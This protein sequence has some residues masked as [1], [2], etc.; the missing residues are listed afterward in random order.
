MLIY[1][2]FFKR[3]FCRKTEIFWNFYAAYPKVAG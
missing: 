1:Y 3:L 2:K